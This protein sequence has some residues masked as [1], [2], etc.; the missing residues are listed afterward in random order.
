MTWQPDDLVEA[1]NVL[2]ERDGTAAALLGLALLAAAG[3]A[4]GWGEPWRAHLRSIRSIANKDVTA[5]AFAV[6]TAPE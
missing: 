5:A 4:S 2:T 6:F 3:P 1:F